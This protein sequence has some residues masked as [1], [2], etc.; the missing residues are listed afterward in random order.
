MTNID[1]GRTASDYARHRAG[2]PLV[3]F[4]RLQT[5]AIGLPNQRVLDIGSGTGSL[6][7]GFAASGGQVVAL[8]RAAPLLLAACELA[9]KEGVKLMPVRAVAE[10]LPLAAAVFDVVSAGQCWHWFQ[11]QQAAGEVF[12]VLRPGGKLVITH[13]DW[14]PLPGTVVQATEELI[15]T[16]NPAWA[17]LPV[18]KLSGST[19]IYR[20][21]FIDVAFGGFV[22]IESFSFDVEVPYSHEDWRGRI[23]A[24][25]GVAAAGL[26]SKTIAAFDDDLARL[27]RHR[28]P[29]EPLRV[30]H[31]VFALIAHKPM[32]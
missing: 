2:F 8:D 4:R 31:R 11:R 13:F 12:R 14:L 24:S 18:L 22:D 30:P 9:E 16:Y 32:N 1:F 20:D 17:D 15:K 21:W 23:R 3:L 19:G 10:A 27:L 28:F 6:A 29:E 25:A 7:R 5:F 26:A